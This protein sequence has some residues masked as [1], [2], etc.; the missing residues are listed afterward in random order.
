MQGAGQM[1]VFYVRYTHVMLW[2]RVS[3][4]HVYRKIFEP[5]FAFGSSDTGHTCYIYV[6]LAALRRSSLQSLVR[7]ELQ[8]LHT[9]VVW[10]WK[11]VSTS[12]KFVESPSSTPAPSLHIVVFNYTI[13]Q[14]VMS[15]A[16]LFSL[17]SCLSRSIFVVS[18]FPWLIRP[19]Y[20][21]FITFFFSCLFR[22]RFSRLCRVF[23]SSWFLKLSDFGS[24][25]HALE[26]TLSVVALLHG[27]DRIHVCSRIIAKLRAPPIGSSSWLVTDY[28]SCSPCWDDAWAE[29]ELVTLGKQWHRTQYLWV[30]RS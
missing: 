24:L 25:R 18:L 19:G 27:W 8:C 21:F 20:P 12:R 4:L 10:I 6:D 9:V 14:Q 11:C 17:P 28:L 22:S 2:T 30:H 1:C 5:F 23:S 26:L 16:Q 7:K 29:I 13:I 3:H 15:P